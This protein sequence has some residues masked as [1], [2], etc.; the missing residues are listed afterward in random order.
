M[1][2]VI[3]PECDAK[4]VFSAAPK[5]GQRVRCGNCR[6]MLKVISLATFELEYAFI[7]PLHEHLPGEERATPT[8]DG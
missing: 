1:T 5:L 3:C 8:L 7:E 4:V 6:T 2:K